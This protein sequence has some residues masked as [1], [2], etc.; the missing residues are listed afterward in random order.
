MNRSQT[1]AKTSVHM[2][3]GLYKFEPR[4]SD[5][6]DEDFEVEDSGTDGEASMQGGR[7]PAYVA[8]ATF[9]T[10]LED[11]KQNG[12]PPQIDRSMLGRFSGGVGS[13]L[14]MSLRSLGLIGA[15]HTPTMQLQMLVNTLGTDEFAIHLRDVLRR[16]YPFVEALDLK[17]ATPAMFADAFKANTTAKEDVL[18]KCR[19]FYLYAAKEA[20]I[21]VGPRLQNVRKP[22]SSNGSAPRKPRKQRQQRSPSGGETPPPPP[23]AKSHKEMLLDKFPDFDPAWPA[24]IQ[25][26]WFEGYERL[27]QMED[28]G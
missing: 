1:V 6:V 3:N 23:A 4:D 26:K 5:M 11:L 21:E 14:I 27:L 15:D 22:R 17:T 2:V 16:S 10:F 25:A 12:L 13:Q 20:G 9:K 7:T 8:F 24:E 19:R 28:E 18:Q